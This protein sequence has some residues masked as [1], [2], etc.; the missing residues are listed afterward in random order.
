[1][2]KDGDVFMLLMAL[3]SAGVSIFAAVALIGFFQILNSIF[4]VLF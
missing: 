2:K 3:V 4:E 1:M